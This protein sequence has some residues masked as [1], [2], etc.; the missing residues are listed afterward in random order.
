MLIAFLPGC[1]I[2]SLH[3]FYSDDDVIDDVRLVGTWQEKQ[4]VVW[5]FL[6]NTKTKKYTVSITEGDGLVGHFIGTPFII[7]DEFFIDIYPDTDND[8]TLK[9]ASA[10][11]IHRIPVHS[12]I[13][14][15]QIGEFALSLRVPSYPWFIEYLETHPQ[16]LKHE[17]IEDDFPILTATTQELQAFWFK[18]LKTKDAYIETELIKQP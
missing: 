15:Q 17:T 8:D 5:Q 4:D 11:N 9:M 18:H 14:I 16:A 10:Y 1:F 6:P 13:H 3:P 12:L 2:V 7:H